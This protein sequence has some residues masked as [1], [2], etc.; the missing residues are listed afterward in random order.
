MRNR[1]LV[2]IISFVTLLSGCSSKEEQP[3][4]GPIGAETQAAK[5]NEPTTPSRS[6][7]TSTDTEQSDD[8]RVQLTTSIYPAQG[9]Y[10]VYSYRKI[11]AQSGK[12]TDELSH[13]RIDVLE[14]DESG[15]T[16]RWYLILEQPDPS[17]ESLESQLI[18]VADMPIRLHIDPAWEEITI[19]DFD[20]VHAKL[21]KTTDLYGQLIEPTMDAEQHAK[22]VALMRQMIEDRD[23]AYSVELKPISLFFFALGWNGFENEAREMDSEL[24]NPFGGPTL[25]ATLE[26]T[27]TQGI[28]DSEIAWDYTHQFD[29]EKLTPVLTQMM[30]EMISKLGVPKIEGLSAFDIDIRDNANSILDKQIGFVKQ[31]KFT[32]LF[33]I[34]DKTNELGYRE[35]TWDWRL[36]EHGVVMN[37]TDIPIAQFQD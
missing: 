35:E 6:A 15:M 29:K 23:Y 30:E 26:V 11:K 3:A 27:L 28:N 1:A 9:A 13:L 2:L 32:R 22:T 33:H 31:M 36:I 34:T 24:P 4:Q 37:E 7:K 16:L 18:R 8:Q 25:P 14:S 17:D 19:L 10:F 5:A 21:L 12:A 20:A